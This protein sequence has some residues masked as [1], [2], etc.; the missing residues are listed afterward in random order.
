MSTEHCQCDHCKKQQHHVT[1]G[2]KSGFQ[3]NKCFH[4]GHHACFQGHHIH[5]HCMN[6]QFHSH[7]MNHHGKC[8]HCMNGRFQGHFNQ[9]CFCSD[10]FRVRLS[11]LRGSL[12][13][14]LRQMLGCQVKVHFE[15][16]KCLQ[17]RIELVGTDFLEIVV[18]QKVKYETKRKS[19]LIPFDKIKWI[20]HVEKH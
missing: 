9:H 18:V 2:C 1:C 7:Q 13:F 16:G 5:H 17:G 3:D 15:E 19:F 4:C 6:K 11:G 14:R 20:E 12:A 8:S 10:Q